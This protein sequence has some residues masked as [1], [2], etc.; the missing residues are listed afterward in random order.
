VNGIFIVAELTG[1]VRDRVHAIQREFDPKLSRGTPPHVTI[2]GSS[3]VGPLPLDTPVDRIRETLGP[4]LATV[5]PITLSFDPPHRFMT[6]DIV[7]LPVAPHGAIRELHDAIATSGLIFERSRHLFSP[8]CTLSFYRMLTPAVERRLMAVRVAE[9]ATIGRLQFYLSADLV[10]SRKV[11]ELA[12]REGREGGEE[13][14]R[15]RA[16]RV[17]RS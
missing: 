6:T 12:L 9:P 15:P 10:E 14:L 7:V 11:L 5:P 1:T 17:P 16:P 3:G 8:H 13:V 2:A 4:I